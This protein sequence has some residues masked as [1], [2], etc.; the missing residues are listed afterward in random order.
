VLPCERPRRLAR[1]IITSQRSRTRPKR[2][3]PERRRRPQVP[4]GSYYATSIAF[5]SP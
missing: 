5:T 3:S 4:S 2:C 1:P